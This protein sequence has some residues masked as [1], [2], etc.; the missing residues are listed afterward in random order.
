MADFFNEARKRS[1]TRAA[2]GFVAPERWILRVTH[3]HVVRRQL[4]CPI[5]RQ[6]GAVS[7]LGKTGGLKKA[8]TCRASVVLKGIMT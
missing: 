5:Q 6:A 1:E 7:G 8:R 4:P 3:H 2:A